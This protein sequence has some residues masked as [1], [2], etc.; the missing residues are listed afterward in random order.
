MT[1][2]L[3]RN[4]SG[5]TT[6]LRIAA[7]VLRADYGVVSMSGKVIERPALSRLARRGLMLV[8]Q[9]GLGVPAFTVR[10][11]FRAV[12]AAVRT[13][14][15]EVAITV[16]GLEDLLD[17]RFAALS[18]GEQA[19]VSLAL[20]FARWPSVLLADEPLAGLAPVDQKTL[21][22]VLQTMAAEGVAVVTSGHEVPTLLSVSDVII[23]S[24]AGTT[25]H[26]GSPAEALTHAQ[27]KR[28]YLGPRFDATEW[29]TGGTV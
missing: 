14:R 1:T 6:L 5:K 11:H 8:P 18:S 17:R 20:A 9:G 2:L 25:H 10:D 12:R 24:V 27:F 13:D 16:A 4:G 3:G 22:M 15:S 21:A 23:W 7:G 19:R 29:T 28:E 26:I